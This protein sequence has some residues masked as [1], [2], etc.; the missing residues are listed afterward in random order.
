[1]PCGKCVP[2]EAVVCPAMPFFLRDAKDP[3]ALPVVTAPRVCE[4]CGQG[5]ETNFAKWNHWESD[6]GGGNEVRID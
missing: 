1:M 6:H 2:K 4:L 5:F 3:F